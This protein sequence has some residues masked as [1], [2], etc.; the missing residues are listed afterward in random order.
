MPKPL[1]LPYLFDERK[2]IGVSDLIKWKYLKKGSEK[3]GIVTWRNGYN[4]ITSRINIKVIFTNDEQTLKLDYKSENEIY[5]VTIYLV[6]TP[7]NLG[8]GKVWYFIYPYT[9]KRCR[10]LHLIYGKFIHRSALKSGLY[11]K[12]TYSKKWRQMEKAHGYYFDIDK[13]YQQLYKKHFKKY[14][15]GKPT[16]RY[17]RLMQSIA[18]AESIDHRDIERLMV[19]GA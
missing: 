5:D 11:T 4:E 13:Y 2:N 9:G 8:K 7:S 18:K 12:Q 10:K 14:Y 15:K 17:L 3:S 6:S 16:K 1:T 19:F